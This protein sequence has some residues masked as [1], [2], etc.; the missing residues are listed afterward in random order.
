[1]IYWLVIMIMAY[2]DYEIPDGTEPAPTTVEDAMVLMSSFADTCDGDNKEKNC[3]RN[4]IYDKLSNEL[5][6]LVSDNRAKIL[7]DMDINQVL[8]DPGSYSGEVK[9]YS[10]EEALN[11]GGKK[12]TNL[13][14]SFNANFDIKVDAIVDGKTKK[15]LIK[16]SESQ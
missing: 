11:L 14:A 5:L 16:R 8:R 2:G 15:K 1:M 9:A 13:S 3:V 7:G 4:L 12:I 6:V 10:L